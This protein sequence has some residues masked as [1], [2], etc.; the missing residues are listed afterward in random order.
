MLLQDKRPESYR[1]RTSTGQSEYIRASTQQSK[2]SDSQRKRTTSGYDDSIYGD[3]NEF[4]EQETG[5]GDGGYHYDYEN[6]DRNI[7]EGD[8]MSNE[9]Y[10]DE[11]ESFTGRRNSQIVR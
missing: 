10:R 4:Y 2:Y 7:A 1:D 8:N 6:R 11:G 5:D 9:M 3:E